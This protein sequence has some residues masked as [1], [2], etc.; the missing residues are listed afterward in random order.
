M[1]TPRQHLTTACGAAVR[2]A[3]TGHATAGTVWMLILGLIAGCAPKVGQREALLASW[4][5]PQSTPEARLEAVAKLIPVGST[6]EEVQRVL[7]EGR[8]TYWHGP[9]FNIYTNNGTAPGL[10]GYHDDCALVYEVPGGSIALYLE[11]SSG[12]LRFTR[13]AFQTPLAEQPASRQP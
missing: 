3:T 2:A 1:V 4:R 11:S 12:R 5:S 13:A 9:T 7:G 6:R 10:A 8:L